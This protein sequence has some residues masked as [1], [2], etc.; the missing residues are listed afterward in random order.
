MLQ[1]L[2][3][4]RSV[5]LTPDRPLGG[6]SPLPGP[7]GSVETLMV[8]PAPERWMP[9][10]EHVP[11]LLAGEEDSLRLARALR[12]WWAGRPEA[13]AAV[14]GADRQRSPERWATA[15]RPDPRSILLLPPEGFVGRDAAWRSELAAAW[16]PGRVVGELPDDAPGPLVVLVSAEPPGVCAERIRALA[17][18]P[19]MRGRLLAAWC[20]AGPVRQDLAAGLLEE[21]NLAG[22]GIARD[23]VVDRRRA[24][25]TLREIDR[26]L[27]GASAEL[28][29]EK[30]PGPFLWHF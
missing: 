5:D 19:G 8:L 14:V 21:G 30:L 4:G 20:L 13:P 3:L 23:S 16:D 29:V 28:R 24:V 18:E 26:A 6:L 2:V 10:W 25:E 17:G 7:A 9:P 11:A 22:V 27:A 12:D 15:P 1:R